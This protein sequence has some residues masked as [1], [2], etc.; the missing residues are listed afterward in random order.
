VVAKVKYTPIGDAISPESTFVQ[1]AIALDVAAQF[2]VESRDIEGM[3]KTAELWIEMAKALMEI[4]DD[5]SGPPTSREPVGFQQIIKT[6][7]EDIDSVDRPKSDESPS[8]GESRVHPEH[9]KLRISK[10]R[11]RPGG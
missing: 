2:A 4:E 5:E 10:A 9:G 1:A 6:E 7:E 11:H 3:N 8:E